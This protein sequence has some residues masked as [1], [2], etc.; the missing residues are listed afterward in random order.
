PPAHEARQ[1]PPKKIIELTTP[2]PRV[3]PAGDN[4]VGRIDR[5]HGIFRIEHAPCRDRYSPAVASL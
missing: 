1:A 4:E 3:P 5:H 2:E